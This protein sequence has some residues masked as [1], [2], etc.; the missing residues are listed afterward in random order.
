MRRRLSWAWLLGC[1]LL[2]CEQRNTLTPTRALEGE[3]IKQQSAQTSSLPEGT[4]RVGTP[5]SSARRIVTLAPGLTELIY[6]IGAE[7]ALVGTVAYADYP[8]AAKQVPRVGDAFRVD[9]ERLLA[10]QPDLVLAWTSGTPPATVERIKALGLRVENIEVQHLSEVGASLL[11]IGEL[12]GLQARAHEVAGAFTTG[13]QRLRTEYAG[14][15]PLR[16]FVEVNREPLYTVNGRH[17]ISEVLELCGG[18]NV[19]AGIA[20]LAPVVGVEAVLKANPEVILSTDG[21][22]QQVQQDW[23]GWPQLAAV[24]HGHIYAASPDTATRATPRL[25]QGA[26]EICSQLQRARDH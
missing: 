14:V 21:T 18:E 10:L 15:R 5:A 17:V 4:G 25:L 20:Q 19:F 26:Q 6:A 1:A 24:Q 8:A 2:G 11:R 12:T 3:G 22:A 9:M 16:V 13:V 7:S 23:Q